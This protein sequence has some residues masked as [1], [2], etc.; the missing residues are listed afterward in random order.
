V[1]SPAPKPTKT[2]D[3]VSSGPGVIVEPGGTDKANGFVDDYAYPSSW[4]NFAW[5]TASNW[6]QWLR[7][8]LPYGQ[9]SVGESLIGG[10]ADT[11][12]PRIKLP[13]PSHSVATRTCLIPALLLDTI[14]LGLVPYIYNPDDLGMSA[15]LVING[16]WDS[17]SGGQWKRRAGGKHTTILR[18]DFDGHVRVYRRESGSAS[19]WTDTYD[20]AGWETRLWDISISATHFVA[21][22][23][24]PNLVVDTLSVLTDVVGVLT[25]LS[26][27]AVGRDL[28]TV[29]DAAI[30]RNATVAGT[31]GVTGNTTLSGTLGAGATT[32][33][34][35][36]ATGNAQVDGNET[37]NGSM[38]AGSVACTG[39]LSAGSG[40]YTTEHRA[41]YAGFDGSVPAVMSFAGTTSVD[42]RVHRGR[43]GKAIGIVVWSS[44][45]PSATV[46]VDVNV[47]GTTL[48]S[49]TLTSGQHYNAAIIAAAYVGGDYIELVPSVV[50]G[51][52]LASPV[53]LA[54][55]LATQD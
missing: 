31:L 37:V 34:S 41:H 33:S 36:H 28:S 53:D 1:T 39:A 40:I 50:G 18:V 2:L 32:V 25:T 15:E 55:V 46:R 10:L 43:N 3:W 47:N 4:F 48:A 35:V 9:V 19:P 17:G 12:L 51:G 14:G 24:V 49:I 16:Y 26:D 11:V 13:I 29:R 7:D 27:V 45:N 21:D 54:A 5:V 52:T 30:G 22:M 23:D 38:S 42:A 20:A 44:T 6:F 8:L